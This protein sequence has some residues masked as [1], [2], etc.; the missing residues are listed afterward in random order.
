MTNRT[1]TYFAPDAHL[2]ARLASYARFA[3]ID[4]AT[5]TADDIDLDYIIDTEITDDDA[6]LDATAT[7]LDEFITANRAAIIAYE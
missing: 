7:Y 6:R 3:Q 4:T 1:D 2:I 5:M